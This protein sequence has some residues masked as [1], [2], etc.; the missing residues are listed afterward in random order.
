MNTVLFD[1]GR[2]LLDWDPRY[3]YARHFPGDEAGLER[4]VTRVVGTEWI[5]A[6]DAGKPIDVAIEERSR[7]FPEHAELVRAWKAG[8]P[9]M[10]RG[11]IA[12]TVALL[13]EL[14]AR[15][16][17]VAALSNFSAESW[18]WA[19]ARFP[20]L[21]WFEGVVISGEVGVAK[22]DP[23][24]YRIAIERLSLEPE[25]TLFV[26][27]MPVNVDAARA[28]GIEAVVFEGPGQLR[29]DL[30]ARGLL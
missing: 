15:G 20:F 25:R 24:I 8:W 11:E 19:T 28:C 5:R 10:L 2:V 1:I 13:H 16:R 26:D 27:D 6:V 17:R 4:F 18:P 9:E 30:E 29:K 7:E 12:G 21:G 14:R 23:A 22:P 3:Y